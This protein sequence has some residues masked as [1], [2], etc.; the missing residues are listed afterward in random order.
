MKYLVY[1]VFSNFILYCNKD[2]N[3]LVIKIRNKGWY[4]AR[5]NLYYRRYSLPNQIIEQTGQ[6]LLGQDYAF[7][8]PYDVD[9][10]STVLMAYAVGGVNIMHVNIITSPQCFHMWGTTLF[11]RW[12]P[13][14]C[15]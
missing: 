11:P 1:V 14:N 7:Y 13:I 8:M 12:T 15:W 2:F 6:I 10:S 4:V 3:D 5:L 9:L